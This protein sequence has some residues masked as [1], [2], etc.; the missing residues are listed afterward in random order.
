MLNPGQ[1]IS[2]YFLSAHDRHM[3]LA[4]YGG[5]A[6]AVVVAVEFLRSISHFKRTR[7]KPTKN[8]STKQ[9]HIRDAHLHHKASPMPAS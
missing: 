7:P 6:V 3:F 5:N 8:N 9:K 4:V 1:Y 2:T